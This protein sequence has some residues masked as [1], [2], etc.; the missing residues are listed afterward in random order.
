[1]ESTGLS[2]RR[3]NRQAKHSAKFRGDE[4]IS[5]KCKET[6]PT[7]IRNQEQPSTRSDPAFGMWRDR[8]DFAE[9]ASVVRKIRRGRDSAV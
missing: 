7:L 4:S 6:I 3:K 2:S 1:M 9:P 8:G 5:S